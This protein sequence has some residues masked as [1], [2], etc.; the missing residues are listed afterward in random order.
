MP[1]YSAVKNWNQTTLSQVDRF[2]FFL[3]EDKLQDIPPVRRLLSS[4]LFGA[5]A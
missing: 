1:S 4:Y 2:L 5:D 3:P